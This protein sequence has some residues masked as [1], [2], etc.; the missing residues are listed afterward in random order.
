MRVRWRV[1][2]L[3]E[4]GRLIITYSSVRWAVVTTGVRVL[5]NTLIASANAVM[6]DEQKRVVPII[7]GSLVVA[8][9]FAFWGG[10]G[11]LWQRWVRPRGIKS[12]LLFA[13]HHRLDVVGAPAG[14]DR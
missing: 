2:C 12:L 1:I 14:P 3:V 9:A 6:L 4:R 5:M 10:L 13:G 11:D 8:V 7:V